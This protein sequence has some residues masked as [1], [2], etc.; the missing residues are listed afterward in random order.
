MAWGVARPAGGIR[1]LPSPL[2]SVVG[3]SSN[4]E[5]RSMKALCPYC[6]KKVAVEHAYGG[7][8]SPCPECGKLLEVPELEA[9]WPELGALARIVVWA[10]IGA[11]GVGFWGLFG[12][13]LKTVGLPKTWALDVS[14]IGSISVF[15]FV[16]AKIYFIARATTYRIDDDV[17][18]FVFL[19]ASRE[20]ERRAVRPKSSDQ[21]ER[22]GE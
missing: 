4:T 11:I 1:L 3:G 6:R 13:I 12:S 2:A 17:E 19:M 5:G 7:M 8:H 16:G 22:A 21:Q 18:C 20:D 14:V 15:F 9:R 10:F